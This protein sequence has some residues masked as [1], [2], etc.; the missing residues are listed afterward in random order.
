M[1]VVSTEGEVVKVW[2]GAWGLSS[3]PSLEK[4]FNVALAGQFDPADITA[5]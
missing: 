5:R 2:R 1:L 4:Y 3:L